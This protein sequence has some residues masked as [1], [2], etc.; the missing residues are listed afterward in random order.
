MFL[1]I[2]E[3][4]ESYPAIM[5]YKI[6]AESKTKHYVRQAAIARDFLPQ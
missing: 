2:T 3:P 5:T 6:R 4:V 1:L